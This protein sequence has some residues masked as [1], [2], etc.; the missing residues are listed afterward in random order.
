[1]KNHVTNTGRRPSKLF[2]AIQNALTAYHIFMYRRTHGVIGGTF[3]NSPVLL[4]TTIGRK[5]GKQWTVPLLYLTN[6]DNLVLVASNGGAAKH[7]TWFL[8]AQANPQ[9]EVEIMGA[10]KQMQARVAV[11]EE[12]QDLWPQIIAMYTGFAHYQEMAS[13]DIPLVILHSLEGSKL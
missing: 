5:T 13:R 8:N 4:L 12:K 3:V 2:I 11:P 10:K 7:P 6:G 9:V 1:M